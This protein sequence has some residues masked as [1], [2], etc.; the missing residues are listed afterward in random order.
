MKNDDLEQ[1]HIDNPQEGDYWHDFFCPILLV[2][3]VLKNN[4]IKICEDTIDHP[5]DKN[6]RKFNLKKVKAV[7][8]SYLKQKLSYHTKKGGYWAR[9]IPYGNPGN[10]L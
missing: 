6:A 8:K 4:R 9:V 3:E 10:K 7:P 5:T 2:V 1:K